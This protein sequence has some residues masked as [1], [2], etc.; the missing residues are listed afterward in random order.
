MCIKLTG[1]SWNLEPIDHLLSLDVIE[2][3]GAWIGYVVEFGDSK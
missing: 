2:E 1:I 3:G